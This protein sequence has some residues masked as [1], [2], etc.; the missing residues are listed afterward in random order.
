[1]EWNYDMSAAPR[2]HYET[3]QQKGAKGQ[4][5]EREFFV[6]AKIIACDKAGTT[7]TVSRTARDDD[8]R[9]YDPEHAERQ[10]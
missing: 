6:P 8:A 10:K 1:M 5:I 4:V 7:V 9:I 3:R 2:G